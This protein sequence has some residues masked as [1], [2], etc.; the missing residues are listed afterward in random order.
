MTDT[1]GLLDFSLESSFAGQMRFP[2]R[3]SELTFPFR[4]GT[5]ESTRTSGDKTV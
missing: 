2:V 4:F 5:I 1:G 3:I